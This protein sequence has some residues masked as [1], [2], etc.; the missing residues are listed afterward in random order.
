MHAY[1][2]KCLIKTYLTNNC[3]CLRRCTKR[4]RVETKATENPVRP[5][6][7]CRFWLCAEAG[8]V[9]GLRVSKSAST[10][11]NMACSRPRLEWSPLRE[12]TEEPFSSE[13]WERHFLVVLLV[14]LLI[15]SEKNEQRN[16]VYCSIKQ[17]IWWNFHISLHTMENG[18][19]SNNT[20]LVERQLRVQDLRNQDWQF[21]FAFLWLAL[22]WLNTLDSHCGIK[23]WNKVGWVCVLVMTA[24]NIFLTANVFLEE[25]IFLAYLIDLVL[26]LM[27]RGLQDHYLCLP[28][29]SWDDVLIFVA[30]SIYPETVPSF[31]VDWPCKEKYHKQSSGDSSKQLNPLK[32]HL[33]YFHPNKKHKSLFYL[34]LW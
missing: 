34:R 31:F 11:P 1:V 20:W 28:G 25:L 9:S 23:S 33:L 6:F 26:C 30:V 21:L 10:W 29:Q 24:Q 32:L 2:T 12:A 15:L 3:T 8:S 13:L 16:T 27:C 18:C 17:L 14:R 19:L 7:M 5:C 22:S 4:P